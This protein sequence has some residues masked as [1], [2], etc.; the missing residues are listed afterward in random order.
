MPYKDEND[1]SL[2]DNV[3]KL[4]EAK[5]A[6]W[7]KVWNSAFER[8]KEEGGS[9]EC[10]AAAFAQ[11]NGV[12]IAA[13]SAAEALAEAA[14]LKAR[15]QALARDMAAILA[16]KALPAAVRKE[17][18]DVRSALRRTWADLGA[19]GTED[20]EEEEAE[21]GPGPG[22]DPMPLMEAQIAKFQ[23]DIAQVLDWVK[24]QMQKGAAEAVTAPEPAAPMTEAGVSEALGESAEG[25]ELLSE[26]SAPSDGQGPLTLRVKLI[27]PGFGNKRD[28]HYYPAAILKRDAQIFAGAKMY[29]TDHDP[30]EKSTRTWVSTV[31]RIVGFSDSGAP[32]AEVVVHD[33]G[34]AQRVRN[35]AK[36][37][38]LDKMAC[39]ILATGNVKPGQVEGRA[40]RIVEAITDAQSV[41]WVTRAGAGGQALAIMSEAQAEPDSDE[42]GNGMAEE[43]ALQQEPAEP[44]PVQEQGSGATLSE[45]EVRQVLAEVQANEAIKEHLAK[46]AYASADALRAAVAEEV[47]YLKRVTGA[48]KVTG[49]G[50][51]DKPKP[52]TLAEVEQRQREVNRRWGFGPVRQPVKEAK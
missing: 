51:A 9:E 41:D 35:L 27:E 39:S 24:A 32:I 6:E 22:V 45:A 7:V 40:A 30:K 20:E 13:E 18:E 5:R 26:G 12:V 28:G 16:D 2:P 8:C 49:L 31:R 3:R 21:P 15:C 25:I 50:E 10:E 47:D 37:Q 11:A 4:P 36:E 33:P 29:E 43:G 14:T 42:G 23:Q 34:F 17:L 46:G 48:G 19:D 44:E 1:E 38:M 52:V